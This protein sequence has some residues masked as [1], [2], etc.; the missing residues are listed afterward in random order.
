LTKKYILGIGQVF[1]T[2]K[3]IVPLSKHLNPHEIVKKTEEE[4][5]QQEGSGQNSK[6]PDDIVVK[7]SVK[8][9]IEHLDGPL[10]KS[11]HHPVLI[12]TETISLP[13]NKSA[14]KPKMLDNVTE[15]KGDGSRLKNIKHKLQFT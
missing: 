13:K 5:I 11:I 14:K 10:L 3:I 8:R 4:Q 1:R 15:Q 6:K 7:P 2:H 12:K 9:S